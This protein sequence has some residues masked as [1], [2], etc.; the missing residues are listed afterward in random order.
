LL[1]VAINESIAADLEEFDLNKSYLME[2]GFVEQFFCMSEMISVVDSILKAAETDELPTSIL[3]VIPQLQEIKSFLDGIYEASPL[4]VDEGPLWFRG[5][6][7][8][9][10]EQLVSYLPEWLKR[11]NAWRVIVSHTPRSDGR[12]QSRLD[13][14][15]FLIDT[16][17]L[18]EYY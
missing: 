5:F 14:G 1:Q 13:G 4:M 11:N 12:I 10:D 6:A 15:I 17:M 16:G 2:K 7:Q 9:P 8:W 3:D 18:S